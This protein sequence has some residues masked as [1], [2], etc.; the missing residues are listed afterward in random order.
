MKSL[1]E[2]SKEP[3]NASPVAELHC[4]ELAKA[5]RENESLYVRLARAEEKL[6]EQEGVIDDL[7]AKLDRIPYYH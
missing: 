7:R 4:P 5:L 2:L 3:S 1:P 6:L